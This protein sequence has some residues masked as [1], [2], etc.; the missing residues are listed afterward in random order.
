LEMGHI[1]VSAR[2]VERKD[3]SLAFTAEV[4]SPQGERLARARADHWIVSP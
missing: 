3:R 1:L 2:F 4:R